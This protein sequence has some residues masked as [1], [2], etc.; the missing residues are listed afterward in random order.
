VN[1]QRIDDVLQD[2]GQPRP[3]SSPAIAEFITAWSRKKA[4][5]DAHRRADVE[6]AHAEGLAEGRRQWEQDRAALEQL[7]AARSADELKSAREVWAREEGQALGKMIGEQL[8]ALGSR[9]TTLVADVLE[10]IIAARVGRACHD[11]LMRAVHALVDVKGSARVVVK[12]R[13]DMT[14]AI[15]ASLAREGIAHEM[16][17]SDIP[18]VI[19]RVDETTIV[20]SLQALL[21]RLE[22]M[23]G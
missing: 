14:A 3:P 12:A 23:I 1:R 18:D 7:H 9:T 11:E 21:P 17:T 2:L 13:A 4:E 5:E 8:I 20:A 16:E 22:E 6:R 19:I 10:P 15:S